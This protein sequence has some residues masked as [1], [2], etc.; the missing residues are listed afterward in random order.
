MDACARH[1]HQVQYVEV[2]RA[3]SD[4]LAVLRAIRDGADLRV[5]GWI[6]AGYASGNPRVRA[7]AVLAMREVTNRFHAARYRWAD[8][9][10]AAAYRE[11]IMPYF[12][13]A[14]RLADDPN[15]TVRAFAAAV[16]SLKADGA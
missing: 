8:D 5:A 2:V 12:D 4:W 11:F 6:V 9:F 10:D 14:R 16:L 7:E 3:C 13:D 1:R 15:P